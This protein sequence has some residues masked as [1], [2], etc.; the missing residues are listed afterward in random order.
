MSSIEDKVAIQE[1]HHSYL[2]A[3]DSHEVAPF[4][5]HFTHDGVYVSPFGE[6]TGVDA[7]AQTIR[8]WHEGGVTAGKRHMI[9]PVSVQ[10]HSETTATAT[11]SYFVV[12]AADEPGI[13]ASGGYED[14]WRKVDGRWLLARRVQTVDPSFKG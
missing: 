9:G 2:L 5:E 13:V 14:Q 12:E 10:L 7:I 11:S 4:V 6:A 3:V 8:Q 1:A